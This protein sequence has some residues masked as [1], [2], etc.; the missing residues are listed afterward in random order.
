MLPDKSF[1]HYPTRMITNVVSRV[2]YITIRYSK[3]LSCGIKQYKYT[4]TIL[5][6][7]EKIVV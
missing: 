3:T 7:Q 1:R 5:T 2:A 6:L 4:K